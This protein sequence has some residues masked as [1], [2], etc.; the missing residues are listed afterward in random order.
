MLYL[1]KPYSLKELAGKVQTL[2]AIPMR[3]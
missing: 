2:M 3:D 1:Q